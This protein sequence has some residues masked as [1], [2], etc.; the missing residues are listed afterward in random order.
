[1]RVAEQKAIEFDK[2][3]LGAVS[4]V[5]R[6][7]A[8]AHQ[9]EAAAWAMGYAPDKRAALPELIDAAHDPDDHVRNNATRAIGVIAE[10][11]A[12][13]PETGIHIDPAPFVDMLNSL[14]WT[15]RNKGTMVLLSMS[16]DA[17]QPVR[18]AMLPGLVEMAH[19]KDSHFEDALRLLGHIARMPDDDV[20]KSIAAGDRD[21]VINA[22]MHPRE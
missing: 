17:L 5:L 18:D 7:S 21:H 15:D 14:V 20:E 13:K 10:F 9:R 8:D 12:N 11:A 3:N 22:A 16:P 4:S 2:S 1:M 6:N 19:W